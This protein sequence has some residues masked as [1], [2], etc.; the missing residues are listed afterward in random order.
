MF[1]MESTGDLM[2]K[3][4]TI[5]LMKYLSRSTS[6]QIIGLILESPRDLY[7]ICKLIGRKK[8]TVFDTLK[9]LT[10]DGIIKSRLTIV[11]KHGMRR[12]QY[13][14]DDIKIPKMTRATMLD[15]LQ[16][17]E[18][19][20]REELIEFVEIMESLENVTVV[21]PDGIRAKLSPEIL[22]V[23]ILNAGFT[24][25]EILPIFLDLRDRIE[26][27]TDYDGIRNK[28]LEILKEKRFS[29]EKIKSYS[30]VTEKGIM[31]RFSSSRL[32][33]RKM[34]DLISIAENELAVNTYEAIFIVEN[35]MKILKPLD[36]NFI[37]YS[38]LVM[39]MYFLARARS[40]PCRKPDFLQIYLPEECELFIARMKGDTKKYEKFILP[41]FFEK[42][43]SAPEQIRVLDSENESWTREDILNHL[44]SN[45]RLEHDKAELLSYEILDK[46][47]YLNLHQYSQTFLDSLVKELLRVHGF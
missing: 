2:E 44:L 6:R 28:I 12:R 3:N 19:A 25:K 35:S 32:E 23:E 20:F 26:F 10:E 8:S 36:V 4:E 13:Y 46:M 31:V 43:F 22:F 38:H 37:E 1:F 17:R 45:F 9:K 21:F 29:E 18:I 5:V 11:G 27:E 24:L 42:N 41:P 40:I 33:T 30:Q 14:I 39:F 16:G 34:S 7:E 15:F 47:K